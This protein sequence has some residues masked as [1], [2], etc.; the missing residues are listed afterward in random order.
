MQI[1]LEH[2]TLVIVT[3]SIDGVKRGIVGEVFKSHKE[4]RVKFGEWTVK[5]QKWLEFALST[6]KVKPY[7]KP[8]TLVLRM[9]EGKQGD[10]SRI[11][12][13]KHNKVSRIAG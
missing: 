4:Y 7:V 9:R 1:E 6:K 2:L 12:G 11:L 10:N 8:E 3:R 13:D 5:P